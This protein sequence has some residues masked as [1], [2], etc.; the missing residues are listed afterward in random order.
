MYPAVLPNS[1]IRSSSFLMESIGFSMYTIM[2]FANNDCFASSFQTW[3][4]LIYFSCLI[5]VARSSNSMLNGSGE[6]GCSCLFPHFSEE[7]FSFCPLSTMLAV[8]FSYMAVIMLRYVPSTP[9]LLFLS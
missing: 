9:T 8:G 2:S 5:T 3:M 7:A 4:P 1:S 6:S